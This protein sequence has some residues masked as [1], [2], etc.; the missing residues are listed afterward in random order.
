[1]FRPLLAIFMFLQY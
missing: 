1:M